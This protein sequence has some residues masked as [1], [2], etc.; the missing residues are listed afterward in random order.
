[1]V[2]VDRMLQ[3][4]T[5]AQHALD[6]QIDRL[7]ERRDDLV[8]RQVHHIDVGT[9]QIRK[10]QHEHQHQIMTHMRQL[11]DTSKTYASFIKQQNEIIQKL[12]AENLA[13]TLKASKEQDTLNLA[14]QIFNELLRNR[15]FNVLGKRS[16]QDRREQSGYRVIALTPT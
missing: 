6:S 5:T 1:M 11:D 13:L 4:V 10:N 2:D 16:P 12:H 3:S 9:E 8:A 15:D 14:H 7:E